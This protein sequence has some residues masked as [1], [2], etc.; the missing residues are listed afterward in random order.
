MLRRVS[1]FALMGLLLVGLSCN[2]FSWK[3]SGGGVDLEAAALGVKDVAALEREYDTQRYWSFWRRDLG[4]HWDAVLSGLHNFHESF[5]RHFLNY[6]W[7][8]PSFR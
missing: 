3:G 4:G 8:T 1:K 7:D 5:D 2:T 6:D